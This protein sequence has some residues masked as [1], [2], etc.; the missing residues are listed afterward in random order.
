MTMKM[1]AAT[2]RVCRVLPK[3]VPRICAA[4]SSSGYVMICPSAVSLSTT[5]SWDTSAGSI[6]MSACG[7]WIDRRVCPRVR[8]IA[9][10]ASPWPFGRL[11]TPDRTSSAIT[12]P[13]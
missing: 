1:T 4:R 7:S 9:T 12:E 13:L 2:V 6:A 11:P 3:A 8:P 10:P 5:T